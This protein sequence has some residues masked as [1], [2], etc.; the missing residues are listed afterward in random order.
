MSETAEDYCKRKIQ[1][2]ESK[3]DHNKSEA[4]A[5]F[6]LL[7]VCS[8]AAPLFV[9]LGQ[10]WLLGKAIP[11]TMSTIS[12]GCAIWLQ[13]RRPQQLWTLYRTTQ[14]QLEKECTEYQFSIE[15][16][17]EADKREKLLAQRVAAICLHANNAWALLVPNPE[18][19]PNAS[20]LVSSEKR[21]QKGRR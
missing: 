5:F 3:A 20:Q 2:F 14:R 21:A 9:T 12:A 15:D 11:A 1:H 18:K 8:L 16:Y 17:S 10:G 13:Q 19:I 6:S 7:I 4:L